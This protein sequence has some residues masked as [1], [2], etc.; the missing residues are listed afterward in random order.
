[1]YGIKKRTPKQNVNSAYISRAGIKAK[2]LKE[3]LNST[4]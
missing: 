2:P 3:G 4:T 1:M